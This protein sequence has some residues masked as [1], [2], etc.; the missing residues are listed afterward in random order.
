MTDE[1][2]QRPSE[3]VGDAAGEPATP[4]DPRAFL[5]ALLITAILLLALDAILGMLMWLPFYSGLLGF[6][7]E[8]LIAGG[9]AFRF[10]RAAR[11]VSRRRLWTGII[12][13]VVISLSGL[14]YFEYLNFSWRVG[15]PPNF[16]KA[17]NSIL[18]SSKDDT[19]RRAA[20][21]EM[22][23]ASVQKFRNYLSDTFPPGGSIGYA[24]WATKSGLAPIEVQGDQETIEAPHRGLVWPIRTAIGAIL[25]TI[26]L[27]LAFDA[28]KLP[29][30]IRNVLLPG[31]EYE[32]LED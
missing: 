12:V 30:P 27:A 31:E 15:R 28:L 18:K 32:E 17:R 21:E 16:S 23:A 8:G 11:P 1:S 6:F 7:V 9:I 24:F 29:Q 5:R 4:A 22:S 2:I 20:L 19:D 10:A 14:I 26:G 3:P 13:L 25:L